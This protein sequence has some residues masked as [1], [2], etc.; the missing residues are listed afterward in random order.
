MNAPRPNTR[1]DRLW[2]EIKRLAELGQPM[3]RVT[4]VGLAIGI[5]Y[6]EIYRLLDEGRERCLWTLERDGARIV[7]I[8]GTDGDWK[9]H[10]SMRRN[11]VPAV[12][13]RRYRDAPTEALPRTCLRCREVFSSAHIG[14]RLCVACNAYAAQAAP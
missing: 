2:Q 4:E 3:P 13:V 8:C 11:A 6:N 9:L 7:A 5:P 14:N 10:C 1:L 12:S